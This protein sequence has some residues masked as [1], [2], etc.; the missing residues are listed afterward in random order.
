MDYH[1]L[2]NLFQIM[3]LLVMG[4]NL[5]I[6]ESPAKAKTIEKFLGKDFTVKSSFGHIR[7]LSKKNLGI[8]ID[9][10]FEPE[11]IVSDDKKKVVSELANAAKAAK[12]VWLASDED[13]EGEAISWHLSETLGLDGSKTKRIV[14][15]E[16]TKSAIL[17]AIE[18]PRSI[19]MNLVMAQQAR[20][21]LD[22]LVGFELSPV[23]WKKVATKLSAGRVQS[24]ALKL[25]VDREREIESFNAEMFYRTTGTFRP[26]G[27]DIEIKCT[28]DRNFPDKETAR[29][30]LSKA[31]VSEFIL[32]S[33][34]NKSGKR[35]PAAPFTT[36]SLQQEASR[37][38][39]FSVSQ[40]MS[41]AQR[42]YE[43]GFI[44]YMRTDS[45]NLSELALG[46]CA[47]F[48]REH[49]GQEYSKTRR[50][51]TK[52]K[53]A[54]EAHEA[55][56]PTYPENIEIDGTSQEKKLYELI[57]KRTMASQMSDAQVEKTRLTIGS[58]SFEEKFKASAETVKFD[59]FMKLYAE[60]HDDET[61]EDSNGILP[62]MEE[63]TAMDMTSMESAQRYTQKPPRYSEA[64]L[65]KKMEELGI[66]R[67]STYAPTISTITQRG[68]II[69][70]SRPGTERSF[71][72][73][74]VLGNS[75]TESTEKE[76]AGAEKSKL[77]PQDI[78][79]M[80]TDFLNENFENIVDYGFTARVEK[81]FDKIAAGEA[82]WNTIISSFYRKFHRQVENTLAEAAHSSYER[83]LGNDPET[84]K[85]IRAKMGRFGSYV[86]KGENDD[87]DKQS[88]SIG[89]GTLIENI[90]LE[91]ALALFLLPRKLG[92]FEG[93]TVSA[94]KGRFGPYIKKGNEFVSLG[95][96]LDPYTVTLEQ[97]VELIRNHREKEAKKVIATFE[98][99]DI[100]ILNG[101]FG[102][103]IKH[104]GKNFRIPKNMKADGLTLEECLKLI[105]ETSGKPS[106]RAVKKKPK[107]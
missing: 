67:P 16:I 33:V 44:T 45:T 29:E 52:T 86:Q 104:G 38:L 107:A 23:L 49:Y 21:V 19:D 60:S 18:N 42:L 13:R 22:R 98:G 40:T 2:C 8:D 32:E 28:L 69:R 66:G 81:E 39:G 58:A 11:Y 50:Y 53:G 96:D 91:E 31:S 35:V 79:M 4:E 48:I 59:G 9:H 77:F 54:Q 12:T 90:S 71:T 61:D 24:A 83:I 94:A 14:F 73:L 57:W 102:P 89:K 101:R 93:E 56:R 65:V 68:Y 27:K 36:S 95:K 88:V 85:T 26:E 92:E 74:K 82:Q 46:K 25:I 78:G 20:R 7:D 70:E 105:S 63:G 1:L 84:G 17:H 6:V 10:G 99:E 87:P 106:K 55:I 30:F 97:A 76:T 72:V 80:V 37:K 64:S 103:Y 43:S 41:V 3:T 75:I 100:S 15:H 62:V 47:S 51:R 5:V 34:E